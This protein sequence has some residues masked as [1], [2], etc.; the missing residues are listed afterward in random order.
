MVAAMADGC[1]SARSGDEAPSAEVVKIRFVGADDLAGELVKQAGLRGGDSIGVTIDPRTNSLIL[2][3]AAGHSD[4]L[5]QVRK[6]IRELDNASRSN[7]TGRGSNCA[8]RP[9]FKQVVFLRHAN[10]SELTA[11][12][13]GLREGGWIE[14]DPRTN[15]LVVWAFSEQDLGETLVEIGRLDQEPSQQR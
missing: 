14:A 13:T 15:S 1:A 12:A 5:V 4:E 6:R 8:G 11:G 9:V 3:C 10:A 7:W 2:A